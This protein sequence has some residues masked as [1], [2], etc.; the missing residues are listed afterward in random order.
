MLNDTS[1]ITIKSK[2]KLANYKDINKSKKELIFTSNTSPIRIDKNNNRSEKYKRINNKKLPTIIEERMNEET[3]NN[4][5]VA[6]KNEEAYKPEINRNLQS[7]MSDKEILKNNE[8][9]DKRQEQNNS[10]S[11]KEHELLVLGLDFSILRHLVLIQ[12]NHLQIYKYS[13]LPFPLEIYH[14]NINLVFL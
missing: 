7:L 6:D 1:K 10:T 2:D 11:K 14:L 4:E 8:T 12:Y 9:T 13:K 3:K 5:L